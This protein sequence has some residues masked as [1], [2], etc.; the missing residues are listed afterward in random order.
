MSNRI[1][2]GYIGGR[3][4]CRI[5]PPGY[6]AANL[7]EPAVFSSDNDYLKIH[8]VADFRLTKWS[9]GG[10]GPFY[11]GEFAF[12]DLGYI[13]I[14]FISVGPTSSGLN[15]RVFFPSD[16]AY[17]TQ[18]FNAT[19]QFLIWNNHLWVFGDAVGSGTNYDYR[20]RCIIFKNRMQ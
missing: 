16:R 18:E 15:A 8:A 13:P 19:F 14:S 20:F 12:P 11:M 5:S 3:A 2:M 10:L 9:S 4:V 6:D 1:F 17:V 7:A